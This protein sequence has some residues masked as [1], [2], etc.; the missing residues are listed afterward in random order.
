MR[1]G[2][3]MVVVAAIFLLIVPVA[4]AKTGNVIAGPL[5]PKKLPKSTDTN[6]FYPRTVTI[7]RG[8]VVSFNL[9]GF[10]TVT[11]GGATTPLAVV[12]PSQP[13]TAQNDAAGN[14]FWWGGQPSLALNPKVIGPTK[15]KTYAG[16]GYR[17]SGLPLGRPKPYRLKFTKTGTFSYVCVVHPGMKAKVRVVSR[18]RRIPSRRA[19]SRTAARQFGA[20]VAL[21]KR[22][23]RSA[24]PSGNVVTGGNDRGAATLFKMFPARKTVPV[25]TPVTFLMDAPRE[26]HT[27][28][29]GPDAYRREVIREF[30]S[31]LPRFSARASLPSDPPPL[32]PPYD[33]TNHGNGF[34]NTGLLDEIPASPLPSSATITFSRAGTYEYEC[35]IHPG[36]K[37]TIVAQ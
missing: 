30:E 13:Y 10:H 24:G 22:Q 2:K 3:W 1:A 5:N 29:F 6:A 21:I 37:G 4:Q 8:D 17:N 32:L 34:L 7:H 9:R 25:G 11:F 18:G 14:P 28:T 15:A 12:N 16:R 35:M 20:D 27:F 31:G 23:N 36:M 26:V 19:D 33:G